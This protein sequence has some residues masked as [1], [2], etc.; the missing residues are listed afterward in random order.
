M[1][2]ARI[3]VFLVFALSSFTASAAGVEP[4]N[5]TPAQREQAQARFTTGRQLYEAGKFE[6]SVASFR[7]SNEIVASPNA[8]LYLARALR[9]SGKYVDA[10]VEFGRTET[11]AQKDHKYDKAAEASAAERKAL[12]TKVGF[13]SIQVDHATAST[14]VKVGGAEIRRDAWKERA[15]V[16]PGKTEVIV[17]SAPQAPVIQSID[18][19]AGEE[20]VVA[21]D[22]A[23]ASEAVA[24]PPPV[25][26]SK[27]RTY[28]YV[29][30]GVGAIGLVTF[31]ISGILANGTYSDL[32]SRCGSGPC[33]SS[34]SSEIS[35]GKTEQTL[36]NVGLVFGILGAG[37]GATLYVLSMPKAKSSTALVF[38]PSCTG[39]RG[40]F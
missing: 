29:A 9:E 38:S 20:K 31:V 35:R 23:G 25:D 4:A 7:A 30:G 17:E 33:P 12:E 34:L 15:P 28:A 27:L 21:V 16:V 32:Q 26:R 40:T 22:A 10:Y 37:V 2:I 11:E 6:E 8:R 39:L 24:E 18:V 1:H 5:A 36:A 3:G 14:T 13:V 19:A